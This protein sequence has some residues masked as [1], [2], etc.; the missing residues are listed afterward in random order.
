M[1]ENHTP[2]NWALILINQQIA[3]YFA[4]QILVHNQ[5]YRMAEKYTEVALAD[6]MWGNLGINPYKVRIL[7]AISYAATAGLI[8]FWAIPASLD[9][10]DDYYHCYYC[11]IIDSH[12][13]DLH[14]LPLALT[15]TR[16][17]FVMMTAFVNDT[18]ATRAKI[19]KLEGEHAE[20]EMHATTAPPKAETYGK[21]VAGE[22]KHDDAPEEFMHPAAIE[23]QRMVWLPADPLG[24]VGAQ[25]KDL[26]RRRIDVLTEIV[27]VVD[28]KGHM[29]RTMG[30]L[31]DQRHQV[32]AYRHCGSGRLAW[33]RGDERV[34]SALLYTG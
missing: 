33:L 26:K 13:A 20:H 17:S 3:A 12:I 27:V 7:K 22:G 32:F 28:G 24:A 29:E 14:T 6:V 5:P 31:V 19:D 34:N 9:N 8:I 1:D 16:T 4:A 30:D 10:R 2:L 18:L 21:N 23:P 11:I 15:Q 25:G